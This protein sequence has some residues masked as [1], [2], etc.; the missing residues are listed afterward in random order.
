M[1]DLEK[2][3]EEIRTQDNL[4][5]QHPIFI[6]FDKERLPTDSNYSD[7]YIYLDVENDAYEI[8]GNKDALAKFV[9]DE[10]PDTDVDKMDE[11]QLFDFMV[12]IRKKD[13]CQFEKVYVK[14]IDVF[15]QA[16]FTSK[17][18][19]EFMQANSHHF[20]EPY[21]YCDTLYRNYEMQAIREALMQGAFKKGEKADG[22]LS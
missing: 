6:L 5:T 22:Q 1:M 18:A 7:E 19:H 15:K 21:I 20:N 9:K 17:S 2:I 11:D 16:F 3:A 12:D 10:F 8:E 14:K 13:A 4:A